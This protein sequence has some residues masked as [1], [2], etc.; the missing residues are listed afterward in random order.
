MNKQAFIFIGRS[1]SG[2]GTQA[3]LLM[4]ALEKEDASISSL[5]IQTGQEL[6]NF[7]NGNSYTQKIAK[8][9]YESGGLF[10]EFLSV[11]QWVNVLVER[12]KGDEHLIFDGTPRR[13]HEA[14]VLNSIIGFYKFGKP[15]VI[16]LD[17]SHEQA[18]KRL[19]LR[20]RL[21]DDVKDIKR[22][23]AWYDTEVLPTVDYY[24][25]NSNY[26]FLEINGERPI[27]EIHAD[28]VKKLAL[29]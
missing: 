21:D 24:R 23:L 19:T 9:L 6:R 12:C 25:N 16:H 28:I 2:K 7:I 17:V 5:Y 18:F 29:S 14:G 15:W 4:E 1:G 22:R 26:N 3:A 11:Y 8:E 27:E 13:L 20:H 10:P